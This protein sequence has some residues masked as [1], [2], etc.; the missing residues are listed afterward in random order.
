M[1]PSLGSRV[2]VS[3]SNYHCEVLEGLVNK[4]LAAALLLYGMKDSFQFG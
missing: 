4:L 2:A 3:L 1:L